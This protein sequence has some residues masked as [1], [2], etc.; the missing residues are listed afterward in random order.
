MKGHVEIAGGGI[1][2]LSA[3][4]ML[5]RQGFSV[6]V[7]ERA[8]EIREIGAGIYIKNNSIE[9]L[10]EFGI[11]GRLAPHGIGLER[12]Q[13]VD[14]DGRIMMDRALAGHSRV[15]VF[16]RQAVIEVLRTAAE[17]AGVEVATGSTVAGA[18]PAG[19]LLLADGRR[20]RADLVIAADGARSKVRES[21]GIGTGYRALP[22]I[23]NRYL[24]PSRE[25]TP[26]AVTR[27]HWSGRYR[28]GITPCAP[29]QTYVYQVCPEWDKTA[30]TLP[31]D[32]AFWSRA[33]PRLA[34]EFELLSRAP[35]SQYNYALVDCPAWQKG[36]VA[37]IGD[38]AHGLPPT[39]GQGAGLT[40]MN[41][42]ALA[43]MLGQSRTVEE[44]LPAWESAIRFI[45][46]KTQRWAVR[47]DFF[48]RQWPTALWFVRPAIIWAFRSIPALN[49]RMRIADM[50]LKQVGRAPFGHAA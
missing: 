15:H 25:I 42:R 14:R 37:I 9:V 5:A 7:H 45:S 21:L 23:I 28:I 11:F 2:G 17:E 22:T 38:A 39:L 41:A 8:A 34:G 10:E 44:A 24:I 27:E 29:D 50:G 48:T 30:I 43:A 32:V 13:H 35:A 1:G 19:E 18:D 3:A 31:N 6:R 36:K 40:M 16:P 33:F 4:T 20:L 47:Y 46:D 49:R 12:A 26:D